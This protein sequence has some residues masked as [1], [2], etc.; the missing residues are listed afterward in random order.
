MSVKLAM[1][2]VV[3]KSA[4]TL[5]VLMNALATLDI[6]YLLM[7]LIVM[8]RTVRLSIYTDANTCIL[9]QN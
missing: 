4:Q 6:S 2:M 7:D 5:L 8:V 3:N 9:Y 1:P